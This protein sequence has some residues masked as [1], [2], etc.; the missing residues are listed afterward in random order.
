MLN[1]LIENAM[2]STT[3]GFIGVSLI[4]IYFVLICCVA[5]YRV[6]KAYHVEHH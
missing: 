6:H 1:E 2:H 3:Q 4:G 5:I